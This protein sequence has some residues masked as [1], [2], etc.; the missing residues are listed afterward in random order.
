MFC[1]QRAG[2][3]YGSKLW[4]I[5]SVRRRCSLGAVGLAFLAGTTGILGFSNCVFSLA[6][7]SN[8]GAAVTLGFSFLK[9]SQNCYV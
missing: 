2:S 9:K 8:F 3:K 4:N 5:A 6:R 7:C 1:V